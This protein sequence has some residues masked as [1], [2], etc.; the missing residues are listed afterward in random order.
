ML[1]TTTAGRA[2]DVPL[3]QDL[4]GIEKN[5][6]IWL[7]TPLSLSRTFQIVATTTRDVIT[8]TKYAARKKPRKRIA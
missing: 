1:V 2:V 4:V 8:G 6:R 3:S 7:I 5:E